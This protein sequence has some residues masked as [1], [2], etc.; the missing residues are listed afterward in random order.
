MNSIN[1]E[2]GYNLTVGGAGGDTFSLHSLQDKREI[3]N[4]MSQAQK[5]RRKKVS[6][7]EKIARSQKLS[8]TNKGKIPYCKGKYI[9]N[10]GKEQKYVSKEDVYEYEKAGWT[11]GSLH[12]HS[13]ETID[14]MVK[15]RNNFYKQHPEKLKEKGRKV[16]ETKKGHVVISDEQ[17]KQISE[18]LKKY[19][20][21]HKPYIAGKHHTEETKTH[22]SEIKRGRVWINNGQINKH[23]KTEEYTEYINNGWVAGRTNINHI[24]T[25]K[26]KILVNNGIINKL[27]PA[28]DLEEYISRGW[29]KRRIKK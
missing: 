3:K 22:L 29:N 5:E 17:K 8:A 16:S 18:T 15:S 23:I 6:T 12:K 9:Y 19:Y 24:K 13:Q 2:V 10:N 4:K 1:R 20:K 25:N 26:N 27:V 7:E 21:D 28:L 14:K 11:R